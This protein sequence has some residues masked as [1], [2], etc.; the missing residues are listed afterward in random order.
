MVSIPKVIDTVVKN[1]LC[2]GCG[3]CVYKCPNKALEIKWNKFGFLVP[4]LSG[5]C[6]SNGDC[7]SVCP[8]NPCPEKEVETENELAGLFLSDKNK[9]HPKIGKYNNIYAGYANEQRLTSSSGGIATYIFT[10]LLERGFVDH[11][12]SVKE[13]DKPD[14][15]YEYAISNSKEELLNTSKTKYFPVTLGTVMPKIHELKGKVAI[16]GV[17]CF[18][19]AIRLAQYKEPSLKEKI[20]FLIGI[21]CGGVKSR[22]F[23][24]YLA[25]KAGVAIENI[26]KPQFRIK[27]YNSRASDY[28]FGCYD[29]NDNQEKNIKMR[30]VGDMWGTGFFKGNA[31]DFCDDV[32]TELADISIGDAWL[33]PF[34]K[35][36]NGTNVVVTRSSIADKLIRDGVENGKLLIEQLSLERFLA[37]QQGSFN[38]RHTGLS[39]RLKQAQK[40][41]IPIPAKR[42]GNEK[43]TIYFKIVQLLRIKIRRKSLEIWKD[44]PDA[45]LFDK[46]VKSHLTRLR[47]ATRVYHYAKTFVQKF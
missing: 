40:H 7:L 24:E 33:E 11:V 5:N 20:P 45:I 27:D 10:E 39:V 44:T 31:C 19:K 28:S 46:K 2:I 22:Y 21:I 9:H 13:S 8:F 29:K 37:S 3:L 26:Q 36:G 6:D 47:W 34:I 30:S 12:F 23:T 38:H 16:V 1:D 25:S 14:T 41:N 43:V 18:I 32:T 17:A 42:F 35:D 15:H 4:E